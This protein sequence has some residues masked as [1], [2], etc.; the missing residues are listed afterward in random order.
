M[1]VHENIQYYNI[2]NI[3]MYYFLA[4]DMLE[5]KL[6]ALS[7]ELIIM[8]GSSSI[9]Q[10]K[11]IIEFIDEINNENDVKQLLQII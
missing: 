6:G 8:L 1:M 7:I 2:S 10:L 4:K 3:E 11:S 5:I 9:V